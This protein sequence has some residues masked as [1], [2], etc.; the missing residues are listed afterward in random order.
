MQ[1]KKSK[2]CFFKRETICFD[3]K[4]SALLLQFGDI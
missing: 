4:R 3:Q 1:N 2:S